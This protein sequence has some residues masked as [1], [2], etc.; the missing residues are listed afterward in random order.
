MYLHFPQLFQGSPLG[1][2]RHPEDLTGQSYFYKPFI[3]HLW[4]PA[5][6]DP[7]DFKSNY[8]YRVCIGKDTGLENLRTLQVYILG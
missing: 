8:T 4:E 1:L 6:K 5:I 2:S 7:E 3:V